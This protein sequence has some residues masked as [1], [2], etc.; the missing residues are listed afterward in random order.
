MLRLALGAF[1]AAIAVFFWGFLFWG[2]GLSD[3]YGHVTPEAEAALTG[4]LKANLA[5][6]A[7][8]FLPDTKNGAQ[9]VVMARANAGPIAHI[10]F[11]SA[12][13]K[14]LSA[15]L[16]LGFLH[17]LVLTSMLAFFMRLTLP[18]A[19]TWSSRVKLVALVGVIAA[20]YAH[21]GNPIWREYPWRFALL[22]TVFDFASY[23]IA[24]LILARFVTSRSA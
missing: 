8:Y 11:H 16:A 15:T 19:P 21:L 10:V 9:E 4:A 12:G 6:D 13:A 17:M 3:P 1:L 20:T 14:P 18:L 23:A 24:G 2:S 22:G 7:V 5:S